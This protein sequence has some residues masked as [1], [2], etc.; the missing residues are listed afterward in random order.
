MDVS[1]AH[2]QNRKMS[3]DFSHAY[4]THV[5]DVHIIHSFHMH[6]IRMCLTCILYIVFVLS[7][8]L[9]KAMHYDTIA[10][11]FVTSAGLAYI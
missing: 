11:L 6:M 8:S 10:L 4:D 1:L 9:W 2:M 7:Y 5:F 3:G